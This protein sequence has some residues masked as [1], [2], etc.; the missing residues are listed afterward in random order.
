MNPLAAARGLPR[1][2]QPG[3]AGEGFNRAGK[4]QVLVIHQETERVAAGAT[5]KAVVQLLVR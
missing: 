4:V 5:A 3:A 2:F 1:Y